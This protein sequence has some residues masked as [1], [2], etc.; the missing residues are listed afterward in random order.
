MTTVA[1]VAAALGLLPGLA[2]GRWIVTLLTDVI[3]VTPGATH[4]PLLVIGLLAVVVLMANVL[5]S[6]PAR[7]AARRPIHDLGAAE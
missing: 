3:G 7:R 6:V 1:A 2:L 4:P 5:A